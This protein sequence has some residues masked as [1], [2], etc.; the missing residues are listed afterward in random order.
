MSTIYGNLLDCNVM[1]LT[2]RLAAGGPGGQCLE[3]Y[4]VL[5]VGKVISSI[6]N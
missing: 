2:A 4:V 6:G 3:P 5:E 1:M